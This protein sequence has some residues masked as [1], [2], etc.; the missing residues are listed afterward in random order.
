MFFN[1]D[2]LRWAP[3]RP[4]LECPKHCCVLRVLRS[5]P[6]MNFA[7][8]SLSSIFQISNNRILLVWVALPWERLTCWPS[9]SLPI[10][11]VAILVLALPLTYYMTLVKLP[12]LLGLRF[13]KIG[14]GCVKFRLS[15]LLPVSSSETPGGSPELGWRFHLIVFLLS[16]ITLLFN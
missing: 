15:V 7:W 1:C 2:E 9:S 10:L 4:L 5:S 13:L 3:R 14:N 12:F 6:I 11:T 8:L 16:Q